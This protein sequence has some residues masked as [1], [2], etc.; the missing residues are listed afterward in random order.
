VQYVELY[1]SVIDKQG[2][3]Q[4]DLGRDE[5]TVAE[6]AAPQEIQRFDRVR[7]LPIHV[8]VMIDVSASMEDEIAATR[9]AALGFFQQA[10][11]PKDRAALV[12][13][14]DHP[15]LAVDFTSQVSNL[16]SGLAGLKAE[17]GTALHDALFFGLYL[18]NGIRGQRAILLLSDGKDESSRFSWEDTLEYARRAGVAIYTIGLAVDGKG[19]GQARRALE[20]LADITGGRGF[21]IDS[22]TELAAVYE[23][24]QSEL[25]SRYLIT[26]Q[27]TNSSPGGQFR[28]VQL[29]TTRPGVQVKTI[30]GYYP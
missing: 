13:F 14:N 11:T 3:P 24:I 29:K 4:L 18:L 9:Q 28:T 16:G 8:Q 1:A 23:Q 26:Y 12:T 15:H 7:D 25:R 17:R 5:F 22:A 27:S 20:Q 6:D 2:R 19:G 10:I 21:F 30:S